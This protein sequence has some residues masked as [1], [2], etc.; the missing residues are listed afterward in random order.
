M[1]NVI[2]IGNIATSHPIPVCYSNAKFSASPLNLALRYYST[3]KPNKAEQTGNQEQKQQEQKQ[4]QKQ[5]QNQEQKQDQKEQKQEQENKEE[6]EL[7]QEE[8]R[9]REE[10]RKKQEPLTAKEKLWSFVMGAILLAGAG[11]LLYFGAP[12]VTAFWQNSVV[13]SFHQIKNNMDAWL[14]QSFGPADRLLLPPPM[15]DGYGH[16]YTLV[17]DL[18]T[19]VECVYRKGGTIMSKR[20]GVDYFISNMQ[21]FYELVLYS[22]EMNGTNQMVIYK[23]DPSGQINHHLFKESGLKESEKFIANFAKLNR[24]PSKVIFIDSIAPSAAY[25]HPNV[26]C[27]GK[28]D[29][30]NPDTMLIDLVPFLVDTARRNLPDVRPRVSELHTP[31]LATKLKTMIGKQPP[32]T[33]PQQ[34]GGMLSRFG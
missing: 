15:P 14:D 26:I 16:K 34:K 17:V 27:I 7:K 31:D 4:D 29:V 18:D 24:D 12:R 33:P 3:D 8:E 23:L 25:S 10:E 5:E 1:Y 2:M 11:T 19:L 13:G 9:K 6:Q 21:K 32:A 22:K 28:G 20:A 30:K